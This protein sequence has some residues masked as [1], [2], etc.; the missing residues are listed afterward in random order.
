MKPLSQFDNVA[1]GR[2]LYDL[3]PEAIPEAVSFI[4]TIADI[5]CNDPDEFKRNWKDNFFTI[6]FWTGL[7]KEIKETIEDNG[8][9]IHQSGRRFSE[10]LLDGYAAVFTVHC[11]QEYI[12]QEECKNYSFKHAIQMLF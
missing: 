7:A 11:L 5:I 1:K 4:K 9:T 8:S 6:D 10:Q 3:F 2:L 12:K